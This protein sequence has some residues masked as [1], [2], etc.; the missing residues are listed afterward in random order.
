[1]SVELNEEN[2]R[3][4]VED[5]MPHHC[6]WGLRSWWRLHDLDFKDFMQ[7]GISVARLRQVDD[8]LA[9]AAIARKLGGV[10]GQ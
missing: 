2:I 7:N 4:T 9:R 8:Q 6:A 10:D 3:V 1:M 5:L